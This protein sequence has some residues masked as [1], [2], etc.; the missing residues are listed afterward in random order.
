MN[1]KI[2]KGFY[3]VH[4]V[5]G[6]K[7]R[8]RKYLKIYL[9][10]SLFFSAFMF[11]LSRY[12]KDVNCQQML[13]IMENNP[14]LET[15]VISLWKNTQNRL[16]AEEPVSDTMQERIRTLE[17]KYGYQLED[18]AS[19]PFL[20]GFWGSGL[21]IAA[22]WIAVLGYFDMRAGK[23]GAGS[24]EKL[25]ELYECLERFRN[26]EFE[27]VPDYEEYSGEWMRIC[28]SLRELGVYFYGLK[29]QLR[30]EEDSTKALV[31]NISHQLKT[32]LASLKMSHELVAG[33]ISTISIEEKQEFFKRESQEI[34]KLELLLNELVNL[35][36]LE[37]HM[38]QLKPVMGGLQKTLTAAVSQ[39]Y[40]KAKNKNIEIQLEMEKDIEILHDSKW[41]E[42][43]LVNVLDNAVKYSGEHTTVTV[44][45]I[46]LASNVL[47]EIEDEGI[48]VK[49][50]ELTKIYQRFYRGTEAK[51]KVKEGAG[52]GLYLARMILE[53]QGGTISAKR[54]MDKGMIFKITLPIEKRILPIIFRNDYTIF[55]EK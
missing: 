40:M 1:K 46:L 37:A 5:M 35:S 52:V 24:K 19:E 33:N 36:R 28:E 13:L 32:P 15:E 55:S 6:K 22:L 47:V 4:S 30:Q 53:R 39:I 11:V 14:N 8:R 31:T 29:E 20:W 49:A 23:R 44:R 16:L 42:E 54:K 51:Q 10:F 3:Q 9:F 26:G 38:I 25:R 17:E 7:Y 43:A 50:E 2:G 48:G 41:T 45:V 12:E 18:I 27:Y 34:E 21:F